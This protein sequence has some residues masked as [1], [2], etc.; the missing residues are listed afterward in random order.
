M[1]INIYVD[2]SKSIIYTEKELP[3]LIEN[4]A[5]ERMEDEEEFSDWLQQEY[6]AK[7]IFDLTNEEKEECL[8]KY[9]D[10]CREKIKDEIKD[11]LE[12]FEKE[13]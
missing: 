3:E 9:K 10:Y 8:A 6:S 5:D 7:E 1:I 12:L 13:I 2:W 11:N 4:E